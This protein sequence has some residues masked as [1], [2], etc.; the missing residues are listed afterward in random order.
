[1]G[2]SGANE[3]FTHEYDLPNETAY[4]ETCAA[5]ALAFWGHRMAQIELDSRFTDHV[6]LAIFNGALSGIARD[7]EHYFYENV[8]ESHGQHRRWKWHYCP[9]CPTN[10]AR[11]IASLGS[12]FYTIKSDELAVHLYGA[13]TAEAEIGGQIVRISQETSY[14]WDGDIALTLAPAAP[15]PFTLRLRMPG[16]CNKASVTVNGEG[17]DT[18]AAEKGYLAI[19]R[20]WAAGDV[21]RIGFDMPVERLY[22]HPLASEDAGRVA[23]K[24]GPVVYCAEEADLGFAPQLLALPADAE[25][26]AAFDPGLLGGAVRLSALAT[27]TSDADWAGQLYRR[28]QPKTEATSLNAIPYHLWANRQAGGMLVWLREK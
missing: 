7:G 20:Q 25:I 19:A 21:V 9:C 22:A 13:N 5:V 12:Y 8:L 11:L 2:P 14:P 28:E 1:M 24:R 27:K 23:L 26:A 3:G 15:M 17:I 6:E 10:I 4:A 16:W 18:A